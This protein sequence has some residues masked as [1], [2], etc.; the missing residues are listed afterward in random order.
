M[1]HLISSLFCND[2]CLSMLGG[3]EY[4]RAIFSVREASYCNFKLKSWLQSTLSQRVI[5]CV[6][7]FKMEHVFSIGFKTH[8]HTHTHHTYT[9]IPGSA[10]L[11]PGL[12]RLEPRAQQ[13]GGPC[14]FF[15]C[16]KAHIQYLAA[17]ELMMSRG[18]KKF[19]A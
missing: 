17:E 11:F 8:T 2:T 5:K 6:E 12:T 10:A 3:I 4:C 14:D 7:L 15:I 16:K 19:E 18:P 13:D 9:H 1:Q